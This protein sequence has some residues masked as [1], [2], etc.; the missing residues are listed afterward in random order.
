MDLIAQAATP[1]APSYREIQLSQGKVAIVDADDYEGLAAFKWYAKRGGA[2]KNRWYATRNSLK[3]EGIGRTIPM[4]QAIMGTPPAPG[5]TVDHRDHEAT[6]DNRRNNLRWATCG[7]QMRNRGKFSNNTS[8]YK[9]VYWHSAA[10]KWRPLLV[11]DKR[12]ISLGLYATPEAA[13]AARCQ[14]IARL[15]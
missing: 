9:G 7:E 15:A 6:L 1:L 10:R 3:H 12:R 5:L 8:G 2:S 13:Y 4:H 14:A 11:V